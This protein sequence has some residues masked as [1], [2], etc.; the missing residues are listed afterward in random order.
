MED[1]N[2]TLEF[3]LNSLPMSDEQ[4]DGF[5]MLAR[6]LADDPEHRLILL[7]PGNADPQEIHIQWNDDGYCV[8][9]SFPMD[10]YGWSH[11]LMLAAEGLKYE[12]VVMLMTEICVN[13][14]DTDSIELVMSS[15]RDV[16]EQ[17]YGEDLSTPK[18]EG[19]AASEKKSYVEELDAVIDEYFQS[20]DPNRLYSVLNGIFDGIEKNYTLPCPANMDED[21]N[22][23]IMFAKDEKGNESIAALTRLNG[24]QQPIVADVKMRSLVRL[25]L[26][27]DCEGL[28][29]NPGEEHEFSVPKM[30]L[31]YALSAGYQMAMDDM[32]ADQG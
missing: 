30:F 25:M 5:L 26:D 27:N 8:G 16:T 21:G 13:Q 24:E 20:P 15:F 29:L 28:V 6:A 17:V 10:E 3:T 1:K 19:A 9:F 7:M 23:E 32:S 22:F 31:A 12:D 11:P 2:Y 14:T 4:L 18:E